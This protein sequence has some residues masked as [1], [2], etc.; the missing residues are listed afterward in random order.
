[1]F[2]ILILASVVLYVVAAV[3]LVKRLAKGVDADTGSKVPALVIALFGL[4]A[5]GIVVHDTVRIAGGLD[6]SF[7][8]VGSLIAWM[9]TL[10][11][12][13]SGFTRPVENLAIAALP[14]SAIAQIIQLMA[15]ANPTPMLSLSA[16]LEAHI[17]FSLTSYSLLA[18]ATAQALLLAIQDRHL[19]NR[20]PGGFIRALPPL[21]TMEHLLF[22]LIAIGLLLL[23]A[24]LISG[25]IY[26]EN[27]F[28][29]HLVHKTILSLIAW[30][31]FATLLWGRWKFG[32][33]GRTAIRWTLGGFVLLAIAYF[34]SK[35]VLELILR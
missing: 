30:A 8:N 18:I 2:P 21:E 24:A 22:R 34:G 15:P 35:M 6:L 14:I 23:T 29:Q 32:W 27:I 10:L 5:H 11:V 9:I 28:A 33:R 31:V 4:I 1:M 16:G 7:F 26:L 3:L 20:H 17:L 13:L 19:R 25:F 12:V